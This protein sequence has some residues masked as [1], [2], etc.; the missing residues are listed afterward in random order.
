[1]VAR[2]LNVSKEES[3]S[4]RRRLLPPMW[5]EEA[6]PTLGC[7]EGCVRDAVAV[8]VVSVLSVR[9]PDADREIDSCPS[10]CGVVYSLEC[11]CACAWSSSNPVVFPAMLFASI[12]RLVHG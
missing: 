3:S 10:C 12:A 9:R 5:R 4:R 11:A 1:M 2:P 7:G 8:S 6:L